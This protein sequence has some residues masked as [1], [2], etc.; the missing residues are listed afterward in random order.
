MSDLDGVEILPLEV[1]DQGDLEEALVSEILDKGGDG[2][3]T[4]ETS[5]PPAAFPRDEFISLACVAHNER[6]NDAVGFYGLCEFGKPFRL[7]DSPGL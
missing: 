5:R 2:I 3:E 7:K 1:L 4:G 6:L